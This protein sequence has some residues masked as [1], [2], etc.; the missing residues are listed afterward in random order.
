MH[1]HRQHVSRKAGTWRNDLRQPLGATIWLAAPQLMPHSRPLAAPRNKANLLLHLALQ[2]RIA[3][4]RIASVPCFSH[5]F[6]SLPLASLLFLASRIAHRSSSLP[7]P[8]AYH[9]FPPTR[10]TPSTGHT[11]CKHTNTHTHTRTKHAQALHMA[12][13][14]GSLSTAKLLISLGANMTSRSINGHTPLHV[15]VLHQHADMIQVHQTLICNPYSSRC[16]LRSQSA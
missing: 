1:T 2:W 6:C 16:G 15:A 4:W 5:R 11:T 9:P 10:C 12:A 7:S 13:A 3:P 14:N 8:I